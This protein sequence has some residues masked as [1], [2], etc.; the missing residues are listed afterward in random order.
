MPERLPWRRAEAR[1]SGFQRGSSWT[2]GKSEIP[3]DGNPAARDPRSKKPAVF[4]SEYFY[5]HYF[6]YSFDNPVRLSPFYRE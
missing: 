1:A 5:L 3:T 4:F 2:A 6:V